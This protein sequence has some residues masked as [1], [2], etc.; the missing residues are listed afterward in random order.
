[1][2]E[3]YREQFH[4]NIS[5]SVFRR[6]GGAENC[7]LDQGGNVTSAGRFDSIR[8]AKT[9]HS[10]S[11]FHA[12]ARGANARVNNL[13]S[14]KIVAV[15]FLRPPPTRALPVHPCPVR[16]AALSR[17]PLCTFVKV[18]NVFICPGEISNV[19][20]CREASRVTSCNARR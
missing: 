6:A 18:F 4:I 12:R 14:T 13:R 19:T 3:G 10:A 7:C 16:E 20:S 15:R 8:R 9:R 11:L 17:K 1:M 2:V 5:P